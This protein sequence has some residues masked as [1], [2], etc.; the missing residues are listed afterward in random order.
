MFSTSQL[1]RDSN[2]TY[3]I[4]IAL[5]LALLLATPMAA[6]AQDAGPDVDDE[7]ITLDGDGDELSDEEELE[8]GTDPALF[9]TDAD[10]LSDGSEVREDGWGTDP[11][12]RD[13]DGDSY[14]DGDE[15]LGFGTDPNDPE[16]KPAAQQALSSISVEVRILPAGYTGNDF[17]GDS[18]PLPDVNVT[19]AIP[20]SEFGVSA[21]TGAEGLATF[22]ELGEGQYMVILDIPGDA[23]DFIT[24]FGT[25][26]GFEPRQHDGQDTNEPVVYLGPDEVL[27][28]TFF[29]IPADAG[30]EPE[31]TVPVT[32]DPKPTMEPVT[33]FPN[34]GAGDP[35]DDTRQ[36]PF[37]AVLAVLALVGSALVSK[38]RRTA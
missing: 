24:V 21:T 36:A 4:L 29:V 16:S 1:N 3:F 23:A 37:L 34:T 15:I 2:R 30:A 9:D 28:G 26:D 11:L 7:I 20:A 17:A 27:H 35:S 8:I 32:P 38:G 5:L 31:P 22:A 14:F 19:V 18:E 13:T 10:G 6:G 33:A 25:E 12:S